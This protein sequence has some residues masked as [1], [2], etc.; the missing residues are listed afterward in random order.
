VALI[1]EDGGLAAIADL[2]F[3]NKYRIEAANIRTSSNNRAQTELRI[4]FSLSKSRRRCK[5]RAGSASISVI[6]AQNRVC[7]GSRSENQCR[8]RF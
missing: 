5:N 8:Q 7:E 3:R 6:N 1:G 2:I 4:K